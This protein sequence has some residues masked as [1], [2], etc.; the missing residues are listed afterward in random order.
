MWRVLKL[1][2]RVDSLWGT[3][4]PIYYHV[5]VS[6]L[7]FYRLEMYC[8][9]VNLG[10]PLEFETLLLSQG[11]EIL[12]WVLLWKGPWCP[13]ESDVHRTDCFFKCIPWLNAVDGSEIRRSPVE[14]GSLSHFLRWV[15]IHPRWC[16]LDFWTINSMTTYNSIFFCFKP[17]NGITKH[18]EI[19]GEASLMST[20]LSTEKK[21]KTA[22]WRKREKLTLESW[23]DAMI[24][25]GNLRS[26]PPRLNKALLT[27]H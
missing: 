2:C 9:F 1:K 8:F 11:F 24:L 27:D 25:M 10:E 19:Y 15:L 13:T 5:G 3:K 26:P 7:F 12:H 14:V 22:K 4:I 6:P 21:H 16:R 23:A 20:S 17:F 18:Q